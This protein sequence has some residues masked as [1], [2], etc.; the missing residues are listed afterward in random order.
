MIQALPVGNALRVFMA[1]PSGA[2]RW[3]LLRKGTNAFSGHDDPSASVISFGAETSVL[4]SNF[5]INGQTYWYALYWWDGTAWL[6]DSLKSAVPVPNFRQMGV[7]VLSFVRDRLDY[8]LQIIIARGEIHHPQG[9][10]QVLT[11]PPTSEE[12]AWPVV[13]VHCTQDVAAER[14]LGEEIFSDVYLPDT[15][16]WESVEGWLSRTQ[17]TIVGWCLNPDERILL[18]K[19]L[20]NI[21]IANLPVFEAACIQQIDLQQSDQEDFQSF[22][23]PVY[24]VTSIFTCIA[25]SFVNTVEGAI[26][27]VVVSIIEE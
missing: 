5:L 15:N 25:P 27:E 26:R 24:Q 16:Q 21:V 3:K 8:G 4:D 23:A 10:I 14:A 18:R 22:N 2:S 11:A 17:L 13:T 1:P 20:K 19:A 7:D 9:R 6:L 12:V